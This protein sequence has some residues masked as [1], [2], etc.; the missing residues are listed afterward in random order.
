MATNAARWLGEIGLRRMHDQVFLQVGAKRVFEYHAAERRLNDYSLQKHEIIVANQ[1][2][3]LCYIALQRDR[4][5][6]AGEVTK[7][8]CF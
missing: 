8:K 7:E 4:N 5:R 6:P 2:A 3:S 1:F